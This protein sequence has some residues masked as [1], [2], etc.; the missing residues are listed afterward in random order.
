MV[1]LSDAM[2]TS[3]LIPLFQEEEEQVHSKTFTS[4]FKILFAHAG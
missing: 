2:T 1:A 4:I 3:L